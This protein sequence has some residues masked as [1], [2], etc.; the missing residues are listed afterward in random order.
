M[1]GAGHIRTF[2]AGERVEVN[3]GSV[4]PPP[5]EPPLRV[6]CLSLL[7]ALACALWPPL[8]PPSMTRVAFNTQL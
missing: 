2:E 3:W 7:E 4:R 5:L 6:R 8:P 1:F